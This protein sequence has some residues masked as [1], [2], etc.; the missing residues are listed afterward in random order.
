VA[1]NA[2]SQDGGRR[3]TIAVGLAVVVLTAIVAATS[4]ATLGASAGG[5]NPRSS[6][7]AHTGES[8]LLAFGFVAWVVVTGLVV[9][10]VWP[11]LRRRKRD[12]EDDRDQPYTPD[13]PLWE[14]LFMVM[15]PALVF[16]AILIGV[17]GASAGRG[18]GVP[19]PAPLSLGLAHPVSGATSTAAPPS[20]PPAGGGGPAVIT[21]AAI[22]AAAILASAGGILLV[23]GRR[24]RP[25]D[26]S[27]ARARAAV[28]QA[29]EW[30]LDDLR[31]EPDPRRA[32]IAAYA[33]MERMLADDGIGRRAFEAPLEYLRR[34][35]TQAH[36]D[37]APIAGLT[38][39]FQ[40]ARFS[41]HTVAGDD[42]E[43]AV[44]ALT[45]IRD[46]LERG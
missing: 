12:P 9:T 14:K 8:A 46:D 29:V 45:A 22:G 21:D 6:G 33:R 17:V 20:T 34:V 40:E 11:A 32:V 28:A 16:A 13:I 36:V 26:L 39:L 18:G 37:A 4:R 41:P 27:P 15:L 24:R 30:S 2:R 38:H 19:A 5:V 42:R 3:V 43:R 25:R 1:V 35:L 31:R 7:A 44:Q 23:R 10:A